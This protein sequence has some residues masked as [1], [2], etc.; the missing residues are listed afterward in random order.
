[1]HTTHFEASP[2]AKEFIRQ[3]VDLQ[4]GYQMP[5]KPIF[6]WRGVGDYERH[7][8]V[9]SALRPENY[10]RLLKLADLHRD[11]IFHQKEESQQQVYLEF[12]IIERFLAIADRSGMSL[13]ELSSDVREAFNEFGDNERQK[14][15]ARILDSWPPKD[16]VPII[17]LAQHH[18]LPTRLLDWSYDP[19][20]SAYFAAESALRLRRSEPHNDVDGRFLAVWCA[21]AY[22]LCAA[23]SRNAE[24]GHTLLKVE[25]GSPPKFQNRN[26]MAQSGLFTWLTGG[27]A[28]EKET[29]S[30]P[31]NDLPIELS[32]NE[33]DGPEDRP[34]TFAVFRLSWTHAEE[35]ITRLFNLGVSRAKLEPGFAGVAATLRELSH[36]SWAPD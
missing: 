21:S 15:F 13:P 5:R 26:L 11:S 17:S 29:A 20:T 2:S 7:K 25:V 34:G 35:L 16:L 18:G 31:L 19:L 12:R 36:V 8:L 27:S 23:E 30:M 33:I 22:E 6:I 4:A 1:M 32:G 10:A 3:L 24:P 14:Q 28:L 9:P